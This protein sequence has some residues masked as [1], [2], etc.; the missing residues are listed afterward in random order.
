MP[1]G[2]CRHRQVGSVELGRDIFFDHTQPRRVHPSTPS[3]LGSIP[4]CTDGERHEVMD[5]RYNLLSQVRHDKS[6]SVLEDADI[7]RS[8][9]RT[10]MYVPYVGTF[11]KAGS[12]AVKTLASP[13]LRFSRRPS[14]CAS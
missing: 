8:G 9:A 3:D 5:M 4:S 7:A 13:R 1:R 2:N 11:R 10:F 6:F 12:D 14:W